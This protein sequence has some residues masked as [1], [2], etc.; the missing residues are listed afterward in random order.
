MS[1]EELFVKEYEELKNKVRELEKENKGLEIGTRNL[2]AIVHTF[3]ELIKE[4]KP[5]ILSGGSLCLNSVFI[6]DE[7]K[8]ELLRLFKGFKIEVSNAEE[9]A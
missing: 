4:T 3:I 5:E 9:Q 7:R 6:H 8:D 2:E 1:V